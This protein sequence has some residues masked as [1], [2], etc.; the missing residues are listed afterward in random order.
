MRFPGCTWVVE[1][2]DFPAKMRRKMG[3][4]DF[5]KMPGKMKGISSIQ[6]TF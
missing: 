2:Y 4:F 5:S 6:T 1:H 3:V